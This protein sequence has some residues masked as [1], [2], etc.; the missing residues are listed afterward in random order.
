[1]NVCQTPQLPTGHTALLGS[2]CVS[3][4]PWMPVRCREGA[5]QTPDSGA[6]PTGIDALLD[7]MDD[8]DDNRKL[9]YA[10]MAVLVRCIS[11]TA[12]LLRDWVDGDV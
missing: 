3:S 11:T 1:M 8:L 9:L 7:H 10:Q 4:S 12:L 5:A 2:N 6:V